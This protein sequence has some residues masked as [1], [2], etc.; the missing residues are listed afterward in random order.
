VGDIEELEG[1]ISIMK[2]KCFGRF[3]VEEDTPTMSLSSVEN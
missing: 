2:K 1:R 3:W